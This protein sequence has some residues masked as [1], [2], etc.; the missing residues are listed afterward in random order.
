MR[1]RCD[2]IERQDSGGRL[3]PPRFAQT[4]K[5]RKK[6]LAMDQAIGDDCMIFGAREGI[7]TLDRQS[8]MP[9][10]RLTLHL[11]FA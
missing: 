8:W 9:L 1:Q 7:R 10:R 4:V 2:V 5:R 3:L 6:G 11:A